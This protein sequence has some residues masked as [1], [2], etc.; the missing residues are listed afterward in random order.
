MTH[1]FQ[2]LVDEENFI[3]CI[4]HADILFSIVITLARILEVS[5]TLNSNRRL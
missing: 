1:A 5:F 3:T 2:G 4:V